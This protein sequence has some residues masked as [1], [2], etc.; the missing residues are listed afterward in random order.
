MDSE[1][2]SI[3][4]KDKKDYHDMN[5]VSANTERHFHLEYIIALLIV[6][7]ALLFFIHMAQRLYVQSKRILNRR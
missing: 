3:L 5:F 7:L 6:P 2:D 1:L 4:K